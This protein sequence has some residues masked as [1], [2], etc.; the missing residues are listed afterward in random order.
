MNVHVRIRIA[1]LI[2]V[3][4]MLPGATLP[5]ADLTLSEAVGLASRNNPTVAAGRL[6]ADAAGQS[7]RGARALANPEIIIAPSIVGRAGS[8]SALLF[9]QP[10]EINGSRRARGDVAASEAS[11]A[12]YDADVLAREVV[13]RVTQ[14]YWEVARAQEL[15]KLHEENVGY[16]ETVRAAV[17]KQYDVGALPG[18][19]L[20][21]M[22]VELA[23]AKQDLAQTMLLL[24]QS[25]SELNTLLARP[26]SADLTVSDP[27]EFR[28]LASD[29]GR[30]AAL[31]LSNRPE[32]KSAEAQVAAARGQV[33][34]ARLKR[35]PDVAL[36]A[37]RESLER[38]GESGVAVAINLPLLDWGST[39]AEVKRAEM[40]AGSREREVQAARDRVALDVENA[41]QRAATAA[42]V[43]RQYRAGVLSKSEEL[44]GMARKGYEK[45]ANT[46][47]E[48]L[49]AQRTLRTVRSDYYSALAEHA[50]SVAQLEWAIGCP[51]PAV[52]T[53]ES[54]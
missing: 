24:S 16:L 7:S 17:Q 53:E 27:L 29:P 35:A 6:A 20:L 23:R 50:K 44:A 3:T 40:M 36:Q 47:L 4:M 45:G 37:R 33:R 51:I 43:V 48:L 42:L 19:Q 13:L 31:A 25:R 52:P 12:Q 5:A 39:R 49:E 30:L 8:D 14:G 41:G 38:N 21:K 15:V 18:A 46:Y 2:C 26:A 22:D 32:I 1:G 28:D 11:A 34:A 54:K 9:S 10:L